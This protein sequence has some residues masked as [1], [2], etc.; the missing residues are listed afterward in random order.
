MASLMTRLSSLLGSTVFVNLVSL[1][2]NFAS[3]SAVR[4]GS[5]TPKSAS[6]ADDRSTAP[7]HYLARNAVMVVSC[8]EPT[9]R[10]GD[11]IGARAAR[12]VNECT[13]ARVGFGID[14]RVQSCTD[15]LL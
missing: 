12:S 14:Y 6:A 7:S 2:W 10:R 13:F 8:L 4:T 15:S 11:G 3:S 5:G 9:R 1:A